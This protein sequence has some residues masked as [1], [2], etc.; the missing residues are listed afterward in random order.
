MVVPEDEDDVCG[1]KGNADPYAA[2][3]PQT[4]D[5]FIRQSRSIR[6]K[7]LSVIIDE[8][9]S[10]FFEESELGSEYMSDNEEDL[11]SGGRETLDLGKETSR[12]KRSKRQEAKDRKMRKK[13]IRGGGACGTGACG[14]GPDKACCTIF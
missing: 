5:T 10:Q 2:C 1:G 4:R 13:N 8:N 12:Q 9:E 3:S 6:E 11:E 7:T 14:G